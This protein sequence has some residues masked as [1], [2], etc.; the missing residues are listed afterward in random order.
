MMKNMESIE[1]MLVELWE[2]SFKKSKEMLEADDDK[3]STEEER[4]AYEIGKAVGFHE[5]V[6]CIYFTLFGSKAAFDLWLKNIGTDDKERAKILKEAFP[7]KD[8]DTTTGD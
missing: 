3:E 1:T 7:E 2:Y 6:D 5:A 4:K 8:H